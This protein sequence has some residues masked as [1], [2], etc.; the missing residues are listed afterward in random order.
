MAFGD[1]QI[2][3]YLQGLAG[4]V[5]SLPTAFE[6]WETRARSAPPP[7]VYACGLALGGV[8]GY[9]TLKDLTPDAKITRI[10]DGTNQIQ[11]VV[12]ARALLG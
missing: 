1:Y 10:Y 6:D 7:S 12:M 5:P 3:I 2:E 4:N 9:P 8:D 11:R